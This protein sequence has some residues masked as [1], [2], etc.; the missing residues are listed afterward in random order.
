VDAVSLV[1]ELVVAVVVG[2][3]CVGVLTGTEGAV[4]LLVLDPLEPQPANST[5]HRVASGMIQHPALLV[6]VSSRSSSL[7]IFCAV[8]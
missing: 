8:P 6:I 7:P 4:K 5:A 3:D 1:V 2:S